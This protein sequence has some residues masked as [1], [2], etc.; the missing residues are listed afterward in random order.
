[1]TKL[2]VHPIKSCRGTS[3]TEVAY[4]PL[5][6]EYDRTWVIVKEDNHKMVTA[7]EFAKTVLIHPVIHKDQGVL[8]VSFPADSGTESFKVPLTPDEETLQSWEVVEDINHFAKGVTGYVCESVS[9]ASC[10][11]SE[12]LS[13]FLG[14]P[15]LLV[16]QGPRLSVCNPTARHPN[17]D[18]SFVFHDGYPLLVLSQESVTSLEGTVRE[19]VGQQGIEE[20]WEKEELQIERFRPNIIL[21]GAGAPFVEDI[22]QE[23]SI[24]P[25]NPT[26]TDGESTP[27][28][29]PTIHLVSKSARCLLPNV[30]PELGER[31][32]AVPYKVLMKH[33]TGLLP[34]KMHKPCLG[35]NGVPTASGVVRVGDWVKVHKVGSV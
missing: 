19:M 35:C 32:K 10:T 28:V 1:V 2:L 15:V 30:S 20:K 13:A 5:G 3:V 25:C 18:A 8:E 12:I 4:T 31:D 7:R 34:A 14:L 21:G 29:P 27:T 24:H 16:M 23:I 6:L 9:S 17:L 26:D 11:P 22:L 33:R